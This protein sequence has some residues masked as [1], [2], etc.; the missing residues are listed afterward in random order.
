MRGPARRRVPA[1]PRPRAPRPRAVAF[2]LWRC[3]SR[4]GGWGGVCA[5]SGVTGKLGQWGPQAAV[6]PAP[7]L[8]LSPAPTPSQRAR[9]PR[10]SQARAPSA[11]PQS[12][13]G[14]GGFH[15]RRG[16]AELRSGGGWV[17]T[18]SGG[19]FPVVWRPGCV[20]A[21]VDLVTVTHPGAGRTR[22]LFF[23]TTP[24]LG[25]LCFPPCVSFPVKQATLTLGQPPIPI[26]QGHPNHWRASHPPSSPDL[27]LG[28]PM[29][30]S[31]FHTGVPEGEGERV[32]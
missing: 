6:S 7:V 31:T 11:W 3:A 26:T 12:G 4:Y 9:L 23:T 24:K 14:G 17:G 21:G 27:S 18:G 19:A 15:R 30:A 32:K 25:F 20:W 29:V 13:S 10:R 2:G 5:G 16:Q 1:S 28:I 22:L 8:F